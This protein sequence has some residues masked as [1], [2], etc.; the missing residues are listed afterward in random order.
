MYIK[1]RGE[2]ALPILGLPVPGQ[3]HQQRARLQV[4]CA[5]ACNY[6]VAVDVRQADVDERDLGTPRLRALDAAMAVR[7]DVDLMTD[8]FEQHLE[9]VERIRIVIDD[10]DATLGDRIFMRA[11]RLV[12]RGIRLRERKRDLEAAAGTRTV[13]E[14][15][16]GAAMQ[17]RELFDQRQA[18]TH[19]AGFDGAPRR[20]LKWFEDIGQR[21][22][23]NSRTVV[24]DADQRRGI[25]AR[26][27]NIDVPAGLSELDRVGKEVPENLFD[28]SLIGVDDEIRRCELH[29][30]I[31][32]LGA[33]SLLHSLNA[34]PN[35]L[36]Q[37]ERYAV[38]RNLSARDARNVEE[39]VDQ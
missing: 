9:A 12:R 7:C 16:D 39:V 11:F 8:E 17:M 36:A 24:G 25:L 37:V 28:A 22:G 33:V 29:L 19:S 20:L 15:R 18:E 35:Q 38:E 21:L 27:R 13:T 23:R 4:Q 30:E 34:S 5:H 14:N 26:N 6:L 1:A 10:E 2:C 3:R 32:P 31:A